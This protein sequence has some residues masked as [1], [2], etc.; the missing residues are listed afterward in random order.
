MRGRNMSNFRM[1][2]VPNASVQAICLESSN[3]DSTANRYIGFDK[4][5]SSAVATYFNGEIND[6]KKRVEE[7]EERPLI[8]TTT[9]NELLTKKYSLS[10]P[11]DIVIEK[12]DNEYIAKIPEIEIFGSGLTESESII[13]LK[14]EIINLH[15]DLVTSDESELGVLPTMWKRILSNM[16]IPVR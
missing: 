1:Q 5:D 4:G 12:Y 16:I 11:L 14:R 6:L 8:Y 10:R 2:R 7:L 3:Y 15:E 13:N 9:I